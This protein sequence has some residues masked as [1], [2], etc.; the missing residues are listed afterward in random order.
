MPLLLLMLITKLLSIICVLMCGREGT[1][2]AVE[3][4]S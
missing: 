3:D 1:Y 2:L 4:Q